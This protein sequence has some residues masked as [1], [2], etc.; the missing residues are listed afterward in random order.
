MKD[1][2]IAKNINHDFVNYSPKNS[3]KKHIINNISF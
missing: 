3:I 2:K 1:T